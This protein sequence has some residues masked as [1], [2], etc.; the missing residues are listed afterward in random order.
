M[1]KGMKCSDCQNAMY[2]DREDYEPKGTWVTY[3][4]RN[5]RCKSV[6]RGYPNKVKVFESA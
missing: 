5:G 4:C 3:V 2:A 1:A 6:E